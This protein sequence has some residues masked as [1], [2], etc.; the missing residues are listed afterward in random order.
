M[1]DQ[2]LCGVVVASL[3]PV[4]EA[5]EIDSGR[6]AGHVAGLLDDGC[7]FISTFGT[8][9]EGPAFSTRQKVGALQQMAAQ[10]VEMGRQIPGVMST[11]ADEAAAMIGEL[12]AL[13]C[14]GALVLPPYYYAASQDGVIAF[15]DALAERIAGSNIGLLLYNIPQ[16]SGVRFEPATVRKLIERHGSR[17][18]GLKDSTGDRASALAFAEAL[19]DISIFVGDDRVLPDLLAAGGAGLIGGMP[20]IF[21]RDLVDFCRDPL[22]ARA[23]ELKAHAATR[24]SAVAANG[25]LLALKAMMAR[26]RGDP[27][28][29]RPMPPLLPLEEG[30]I[31]EIETV[32][33]GTGFSYGTAAA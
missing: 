16:L 28:W 12:D 6:L 4:T 22:S 3:T 14:R 26:Y 11:S 24:I 17:I 30:Q 33:A 8:T 23:P 2:D 9:G 32:F 21:T 20:N 25:D 29:S 5:L 19:P 27:A 13:G 10:G 7:G 31:N 18:I 15:F 1:R